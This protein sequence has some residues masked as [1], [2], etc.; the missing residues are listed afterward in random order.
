MDTLPP[1]LHSLI[2]EYACASPA[3]GRTPLALSLINAY[4]HAVAAPFVFHTL[5]I[6]SP[7]QATPILA[8]L[9]ATPAPARRIHRLLLGPALPAPA[10]LALLHFAA[11]TLR[12]LA[13]AGAPALLAAALRVPLP[14]LAALAVRGLYP[15]PHAGAL[16][17][18]ERLHLAGNRAPAGLPTALARA[19]PALT[20]LRVAGLR[21]APA[22]AKEVR[23][24]L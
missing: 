3:G 23:A 9:G 18:L 17:A 7:T 10:A 21:G 6:S 16:P 11:P 13:L 1:E 12:V 4:F 5:A 20:H 2:L 8:L 19:C 15:L 22:F 14:R 24:A